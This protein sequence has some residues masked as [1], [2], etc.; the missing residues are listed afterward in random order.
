[1][2]DYSVKLGDCHELLASIPSK[3]IDMILC[4]PPY[5]LMYH[6]D[7]DKPLDWALIWKH[8]KRILKC[9]GVAV[10]FASGVF[11]YQLYNTA[12]N[13]Y[14]HKYVWYKEGFVGNF[15]NAKKAP[16]NAFE[17][18]LVF[19]KK[20]KYF[21]QKT[22]GHSNYRRERS[23]RSNSLYDCSLNTAI[24]V[25]DGARYPTNFVSCPVLGSMVKRH[26][27]EKP[28]PLLTKL[29]K[30]YSEPNDTILDFTMGSASTGIAALSTDRNFIG[31]ESDPLF[32]DI[33]ESRLKEF[34]RGDASS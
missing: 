5:G 2:A 9:P 19:G 29:I 12:P 11:T 4:D 24:E 23:P 30:T 26:P 33:A 34:T 6:V 22:Y 1:M 32:F 8:I 20:G 27:T 7:W 15:L 16:L 10:F 14:K 3:S 28:Q 25:N 18:I 13:W 31:F 17:E 21:P